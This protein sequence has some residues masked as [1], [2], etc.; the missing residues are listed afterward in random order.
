M[1]NLKYTQTDELQKLID[2]DA[3]MKMPRYAGGHDE[4][5]TG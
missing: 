3:I 2:W 1:E 5:M 4:Q